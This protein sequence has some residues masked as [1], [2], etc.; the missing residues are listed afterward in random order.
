LGFIYRYL[1][2]TGQRFLGGY[3]G[4]DLELGLRRL[5]TMPNKQ[6]YGEN[7]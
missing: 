7:K 5:F 2:R 6:Q 1:N 4:G 3:D